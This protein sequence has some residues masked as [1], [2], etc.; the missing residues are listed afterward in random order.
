MS[1]TIVCIV[2]LTTLLVLLLL[3][4]VVV[5]LSLL[6][7]LLVVV[8][9]LLLLLLVVILSLLLVLMGEGGTGMLV[10]SIK[11]HASIRGSHLSNTTCLTHV[12][13]K[14]GESYSKFNWPY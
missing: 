13:F 12:F 1:V 6:L 8:V 9:L 2:M 10:S 3:V 5:L 7:L 11:Q 14:S 4:V